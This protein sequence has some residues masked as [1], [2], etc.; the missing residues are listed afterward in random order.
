MIVERKRELR[1]EL[2]IRRRALPPTRRER[3]GASF[4]D[5]L[6]DQPELESAA[7]VAAYISVGSEPETTPLLEAL[8]RRGRAVLLPVTLPDMTLDWAPYA[9]PD[10]LAEG[11]HGLRE[12]AGERLGPEAVCEVD[13]VV[14]PALAVDRTGLRMGRGGGC[15]DRVLAKLPDTT[16]SCVL[17]YEHELVDEVPAEPHDRRVRAAATPAGLHRF[18][19]PSR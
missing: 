4:R 3:A 1:R 15:Y 19:P 18:V 17:V 14:L 5:I 10:S 11:P 6:L 8:S 2:A 9:G 7:Y 16:F 13:A 12:P